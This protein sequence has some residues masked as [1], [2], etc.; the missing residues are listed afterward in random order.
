[1]K[2]LSVSVILIVV[3]ILVASVSESDDLKISKSGAYIFPTAPYDV[4]PVLDDFKCPKNWFLFYSKTDVDP[5]YSA[6]TCLK[7]S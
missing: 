7:E 3:S 2:K 5:N 1:M 6:V 4:I